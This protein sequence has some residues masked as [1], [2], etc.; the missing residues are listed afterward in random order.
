MNLLHWMVRYL[1]AFAVINPYFQVL[2]YNR[3]QP[4]G[5]TGLCLQSTL[6]PVLTS[7]TLPP[8]VLLPS[9]NRINQLQ[10]RLGGQQAECEQ[11]QNALS[12]LFSGG[13][14]PLIETMTDQLLELAPHFKFIILSAKRAQ[15]LNIRFE[16]DPASECILINSEALK[17]MPLGELISIMRHEIFH[18]WVGVC[19][20]H[21]DGNEQDESAFFGYEHET[22]AIAKELRELVLGLKSINDIALVDKKWVD[23]I[24][25]ISDQD[26]QDPSHPY[27]M[28]KTYT[29]S[30]EEYKFFKNYKKI[31]AN[32][33]ARQY[34]SSVLVLSDQKTDKGHV[35]EF[36]Y[37]QKHLHLL[38]MINDMFKYYNKKAST[39]YQ[40]NDLDVMQEYI[41][42]LLQVLPPEG[43]KILAP[44]AYKMIIHLQGKNETSSFRISKRTPNDSMFSFGYVQSAQMFR[45]V[46]QEPFYLG[47][48]KNQNA[49]ESKIKEMIENEYFD[50][51]GPA[52]ESITCALKRPDTHLPNA[53]THRL[54]NYKAE[55]LERINEEGHVPPHA[56]HPFTCRTAL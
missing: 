10:E 31:N 27:F 45:R 51:Y 49:F 29:F 12:G 32:F 44:N 33:N 39:N 16:Y 48:T 11:V 42:V 55:I 20:H 54:R 23:A 37:K 15:Q 36:L 26:F 56:L 9:E 24:N 4:Q 19:I 38:S 7:Y 34:V 25:T 50:L 13:D 52:I 18:A 40:G 21:Y 41:A 35:I 3:P 22:V 47:Q 30:E 28:P 43:V 17:K 2:A 8:Q 46:R 1:A 5:G 6:V 53:L 14:Y